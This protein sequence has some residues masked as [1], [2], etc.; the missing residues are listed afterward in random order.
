MKISDIKPEVYAL[1]K[2]VEAEIKAQFE[3]IDRTAE[4]NT[5][6]VMSA[7]QDNKVSDTCYAGTSGYGYL[8][9]IHI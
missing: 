1:A 8:S 9:L 3:R 5:I 2:E 7:F 6:K 4:L